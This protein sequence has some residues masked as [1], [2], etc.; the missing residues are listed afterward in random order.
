MWRL[1]V[2]EMGFT[3]VSISLSSWRSSSDL[4]CRGHRGLFHSSGRGFARDLVSALGPPLIPL[5]AALPPRSARRPDA[6]W[7]AWFDAIFRW[8]LALC[9]EPRLVLRHRTACRVAWVARRLVGCSSDPQ[10]SFPPRTR[11]IIVVAE[12]WR[13]SSPLTDSCRRSQ[14]IDNPAWRR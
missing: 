8:T 13:H 2:Q 11:Q 3:I 1:T 6:G 5:L 14:A 4:S 10:G 12:P 7:T 9:R